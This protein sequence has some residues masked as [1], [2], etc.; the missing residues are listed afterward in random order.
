LFKL[1]QV[2]MAMSINKHSILIYKLI[3]R[4]GYSLR[5]REQ[6]QQVVRNSKFE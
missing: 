1:F 4:L 5:K 6:N 3:L 2:D